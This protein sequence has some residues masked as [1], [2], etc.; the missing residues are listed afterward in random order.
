MTVFYFLL[1]DKQVHVEL[2]FFLRT[3]AY[4]CDPSKANA[5]EYLHAAQPV[6]SCIVSMVEH[7]SAFIAH[8]FL[9][10]EILKEVCKIGSAFYLVDHK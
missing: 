10:T 8:S 5:F 3:I 2:A 7:V 9:Q 4:H 1:C 6:C